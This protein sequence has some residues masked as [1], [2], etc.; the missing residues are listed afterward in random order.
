MKSLF[1]YDI[2]EAHVLTRVYLIEFEESDMEIKS[3]I[4]FRSWQRMPNFCCLLG[5]PTETIYLFPALLNLQTTIL[6]T[7]IKS[8]KNQQIRSMFYISFPF[9]Q[10]M[11]NVLLQETKGCK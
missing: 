7:E 1:R 3:Q 8:T 2:S 10:E 11:S 9:E 4:L 5:R 6:K